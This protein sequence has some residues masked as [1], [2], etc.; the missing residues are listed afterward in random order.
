MIRL[1]FDHH[2]YLDRITMSQNDYY[3]WPD[4][5]DHIPE[6]EYLLDIKNRNDR[7]LATQMQSQLEGERELG[8]EYEWGTISSTYSNIHSPN[9]EIIIRIDAWL[10]DP[11]FTPSYRSMTEMM[12]W[13]D[14]DNEANPDSSK[15]LEDD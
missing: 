9:A 14:N 12:G 13:S 5:P 2:D 15:N 4:W 6:K 3:T 11:S 8:F 1:S 10:F 7:F